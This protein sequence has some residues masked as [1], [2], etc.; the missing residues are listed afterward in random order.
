LVTTAF[1]VTERTRMR[2]RP[3][4]ARYDRD[5]V[6]AILDEPLIASV[7]VCID[8][9]PHV[10]P[11]IHVR[12]GDRLILHGSAKNRLLSHIAAGGEAC[13][14]VAIV[15]AL[16]L[17]R[18]TPDHT[19][20]YRSAT[21]YGR[22]TLVSDEAEKLRLMHTVF[23]HL[24]KSDRLEHLPPLPEG[25]LDGTMVVLV[26]IDEAVAKVNSGIATD[27]GADGIWSG[28]VPVQVQRLEPIP[29]ERTRGEDARLGAPVRDLPP[30]AW[31]VR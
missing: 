21:V 6:H 28:L 11:M 30:S 23:N 4:R 1:P 16:V 3:A 2:R 10:Q 12:D 26:P 18:R 15:D 25:Y 17:A 13:I 8:G 29:D 24:V 9:Q 19:M 14:N 7:A 31:D 5:V 20:H 27:D 22:G